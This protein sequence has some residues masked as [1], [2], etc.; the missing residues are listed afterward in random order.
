MLQKTKGIVLHNIKYGDSSIIAHIYTR[1]FG[2]QSYL[3]NGVRQKKGKFHFNNFQPLTI[4]DLEVEHKPTRELQRIRELYIEHPFHHLH[5]D[6]VKNTIALF[7]GE[8]LY[9]TLNDVEKNYPLF[10]YLGSA[11]QILDYC[12][13]GCVNFHLV[14]LVQFTRFLGIY[15]ENKAEIEGYQPQGSSVSLVDI[16]SFSLRSLSE[17][18]I[19]K[20][21]RN[22]LMNAML[23]Y[24]YYHI[25]GM[26][27]ITSI[28]ILHEV[29]S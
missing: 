15:P 11:I 3:V 22:Q 21:S 1:D 16:L 20:Y 7:I 13:E 8:V 28:D 4:V 29:F 18:K 6:I 17:V 23:D 14:F 12:Q 25:E 26:G 24:Y 10:D 5:S 27:K 19:D 2:R 9:R